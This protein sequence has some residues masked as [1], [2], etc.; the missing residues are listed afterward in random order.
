MQ[1]PDDRHTHG[2]GDH[3]HSHAPGSFGFA[4]ALGTA[5]N[6]GFVIVEAIFGFLSNS[7]ALLAD[8]GHNLSDVLGLLVAWT[9]ATLSRRPPSARYTY[10]LRS[11][12]ILAALFNGMFLLVAVGA[13]AWEAI[14]RFSAPVPVAGATVMV[15]AAIGIVINGATALL[16][17][18]GRKGDLNIRGAYLHMMADAAVS[19]GVVVAGLVVLLTG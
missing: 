15:V 3:P 8:A 16:F 14:Q 1:R 6:V 10:G 11:S 17:A 7:T 18:S 9:A 5:L 2:Q 4:F 12:S 19:A 13:I